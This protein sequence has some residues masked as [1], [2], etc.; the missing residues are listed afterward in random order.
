MEQNLLEIKNGFNFRDIG[1]YPTT[2]GRIIK[3]H[4]VVRSGKLSSLSKDDLNYLNDYGVR[5][6]I[7]FRS[8]NEQQEYPDKVPSMAKYINDSV[9]PADETNSTAKDQMRKQA[10]KEDPEAGYNDMLKSY[11]DIVLAS[12]A[13][14]A[15]RVFFDELLANSTDGEAVLFHCT[16]GKDR[17]GMGAVYLMSVLGVSDEII[18]EDYLSSNKHLILNQQNKQK[19]YHELG[20]V[21]LKNI[22][23]LTHVYDEYLDTA[24]NIIRAE[25]GN[26]RNYVE[27]VLK[28]TPQQQRDLRKIYLTDKE[29]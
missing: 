22:E 6:D 17:T 24:L 7:D 14:H 29:Q 10:F 18:R 12:S 21:F 16:A 20:P 25:S 5:V 19:L 27:R 2:D 9:F 8:P 1:G 15:Y 26:V 4:K 28:V 23:A 3:M 11:K 13:Q